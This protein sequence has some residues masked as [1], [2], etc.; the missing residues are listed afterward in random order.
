MAHA[1][2]KKEKETY[3]ITKGCCGF[4]S[5]LNC[6]YGRLMEKERL[7]KDFSV[8]VSPVDETEVDLFTQPLVENHFVW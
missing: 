4:K 8:E 1:M 7:L 5:I 2:H 3:E 6:T